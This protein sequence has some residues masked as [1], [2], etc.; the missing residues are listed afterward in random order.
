MVI[1]LTAESILLL[2]YPLSTPKEISFSKVNPPA[3]ARAFCNPNDITDLKTEKI[4]LEDEPV[5]NNTLR[6]L[7]DIAKEY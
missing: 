4:S 6:S 3:P 5:E 2:V 7:V 1:E